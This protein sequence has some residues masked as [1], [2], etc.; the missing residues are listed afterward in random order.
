MCGVRFCA[1]PP[2]EYVCLCASMSCS[3]LSAYI[4]AAVVCLTH[5]TWVVKLLPLCWQHIAC[6]P[7]A[8][9]LLLSLYCRESWSG[10]ACACR[11]C[12]PC[13]CCCMA[14]RQRFVSVFTLQLLSLYYCT[15]VPLYTSLSLSLCVLGVCFVLPVLACVCLVCSTPLFACWQFEGLAVMCSHTPWAV[16]L[17]CFCLLAYFVHVQRATMQPAVGTALAVSLFCCYY[18]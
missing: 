13:C 3:Q 9:R 5:H 7:S 16:L 17:V 18:C 12:R 8:C 11:M 4:Q 1:P 15:A 6:S 14:F 10:P 2:L